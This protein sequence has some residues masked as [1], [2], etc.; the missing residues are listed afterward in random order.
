[1]NGWDLLTWLAAASLAG[2][3]SVIFVFFLRDAGDILRLQHDDDDD[4]S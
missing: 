4:E 1:V 2:S 3:A